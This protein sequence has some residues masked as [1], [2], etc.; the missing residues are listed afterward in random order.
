MIKY[1]GKAK[2]FC[3]K[4]ANWKLELGFSDSK[5][6]CKEHKKSIENEMDCLPELDRSTLGEEQAMRNI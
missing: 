3:G 1:K 2:C 4:R 6:R 5:F